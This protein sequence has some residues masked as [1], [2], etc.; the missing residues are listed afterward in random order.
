VA[1]KKTKGKESCPTIGPK[2]GIAQ[3]SVP[4]GNG[5]EFYVTE[6][7]R[8]QGQGQVPKGSPRPPRGKRSYEKGLTISETMRYAHTRT[9]SVQPLSRGGTKDFLNR[10]GHIGSLGSKRKMGRMSQRIGGDKRGH[11][12][13]KARS[14]KKTCWGKERQ[15]K[16]GVW[17]RVKHAGGM[18]RRSSRKKQKSRERATNSAG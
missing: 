17:S 14:K 5:G 8:G 3:S 9:K 7:N 12:L 10:N 15:P 2:K 1:V 4:W 16:V 13:G 6:A 11:S 18:D